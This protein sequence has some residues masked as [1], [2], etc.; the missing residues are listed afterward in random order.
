MCNKI[1]VYGTLRYGGPANGFLEGAKYL[2]KD[3]IPAY[4][5]HLGWY[6]GIKLVDDPTK[7][8]AATVVDVYEL[9]KGEIVDYLKTMDRYEGY[10][11]GHPE[12][13]LFARKKILL[14]SNNEEVFV[15]E[16]CYD[17]NDADLIDDG[18]WFSASKVS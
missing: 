2:G 17:V 13:S 6:P 4:L 3:T 14:N 15:Y 8:D 7:S 5:Y 11:P 16:Y 10:S 1:A 12:E 18:D 9:P